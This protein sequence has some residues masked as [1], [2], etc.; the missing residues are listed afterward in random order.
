MI[1]RRSP[2]RKNFSQPPNETVF[3]E[4]MGMLARMVLVEILAR[5]PG[6]ETTAQQMWEKAYRNRGARA[7]GKRAYRTAFAELEEYGYMTRETKKIPAGKP[8]G[9]GFVT[10]LTVFNY[11]QKPDI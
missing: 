8:G 3:D 5:P 1:V 2:V 11:S 4:R 10:V 9:G 6:W 7:E